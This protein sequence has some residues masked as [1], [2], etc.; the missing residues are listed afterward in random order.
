M[1]ATIV[2]LVTPHVLRVVDLANL[3]E[4]G[5]NVDW[6][7]RDAVAKTI[8]DL[9]HQYNYRD[10]LSAYVQGLETA[11][12]DAARVR[13]SYAGVLQAAAALATRELEKGE[14]GVSI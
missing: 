7:V 9:A 13:Q 6:H 2:G 12:H 1:K 11:A 10:L 3:A 5:A 14:G 8:G 4:T